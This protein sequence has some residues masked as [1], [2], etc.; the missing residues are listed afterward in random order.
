MRQIPMRQVRSGA[1]IV[2]ALE[3]VRHWRVIKLHAESVPAAQKWLALSD[4]RDRFGDRFAHLH[5]ESSE[6]D[7]ETYRFA[8]EIFD[9]FAVSTDADEA[10]LTEEEFFTSGAHHMGTCRMGRDVG[11]SVVNQFSQVYGIP[12]LYVAGGSSFP[13]TSPVNPTLTMV[14]L[15]M[16]TAAHVMDQAL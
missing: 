6:F 2:A 4:R 16:R 8:R 12:N 14:A 1:D 13:G 7:H 9:R 3:P 11:D 5:Y 10:F 15:A